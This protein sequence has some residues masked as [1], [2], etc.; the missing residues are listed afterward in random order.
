MGETIE[1]DVSVVRTG[2]ELHALIA[3]TLGF[4]DYYGC[5]WDAFWDC[6]RDPEQSRMP[7]VLRV[8]GLTALERRLPR[9]AALLRN[10][11]GDLGSERSDCLVEWG[12]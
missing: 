4:P 2:P 6:I 11:L 3:T 8:R 7:A 5:N 9:D 10:C 1:L 12:A